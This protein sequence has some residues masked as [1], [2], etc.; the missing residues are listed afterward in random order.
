MTLA[1]RVV[2]VHRRTELD[3]LVA[4]H[5]TLGQV[6][7]F[8]S[9]RGRDLGEVSERH[10][11]MQVALRTV[12]AAIPLDW[13][14]GRIERADLGQFLFAPE[15]IV[16][17]VGQDGLVANV[18]KYLDGQPVIGIDPSPAR[19]V[20]VLVRHRPDEA[21][22]LLRAHD[23]VEE[24]VMV[25]ACAD[26]GQRLV[27][28]NEIYLGHPS[29]QTARY[30]LMPPGSAAEHQASSGLIV[31]TGTGSTGWCRSVWLERRSG[32][33]LPGPTEQRLL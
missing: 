7:F 21:G 15:D 28:L 29:H 8:L 31:A 10:E 27:A 23:A 32:L 2:I 17:V 30:Q 26:D 9:T 12:A 5:G 18:A 11:A 25:E 4:R 22:E 24:R 13:R 16:V 3:E 1:P 19:N 33:A 20:G 6:A 14:R